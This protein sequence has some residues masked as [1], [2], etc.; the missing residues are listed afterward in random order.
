MDT[1]LVSMFNPCRSKMQF[2]RLS[3]SRAY[4]RLLEGMYELTPAPLV[5]VEFDAVIPIV[6]DLTVNKSEG[7]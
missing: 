3:P 6:S 2:Q 5:L 4:I 1:F 7:W